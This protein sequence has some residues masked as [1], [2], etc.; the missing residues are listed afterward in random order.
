LRR[1]SVLKNDY[2]Q[3]INAA[4]DHILNNLD[5]PLPLDTVADAAGL[6][7]FHFHRVFK[8]IQGETLLE[9]T[10]RIRLERAISKMT[11]APTRPL[12][13]VATECGFGSQS[14]FSRCFKKRFGVA[15]SAFDVDSF[16]DQRRQEWKSTVADEKHI[17]QLKG[18]PPGVNPDGFT[19]RIRELPARR[20]AYIRVLDPYRPDVVA[21]AAQR[22]VVWAEQH[23]L[24]G[25]QW[26]GYMWEDPEVT[27]TK[28]CRYDAAVEA[29]RFT[30]EGEVCSHT[31][32][33]MLVAQVDIRGPIDVEVRALDW[34]FKTWLPK[35]GY[36]PA[37]QPAFEAWH[38]LPFAHGIEHF[39]L[40]I[41]LP[42]E[43]ARRWRC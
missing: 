18:L 36:V 41:Q 40:S 25:G 4:I 39:E 10:Q 35:S 9:F 26:L 3:R 8:A 17:H 33:P 29:E 2:V 6:S 11:H 42:I 19:A 20:V 1:A 15:P 27:D 24:A 38:G 12:A 5:Q 21:N 32:P 7:P 28:R 43:S 37:A 31:F 22:L 13:D 34:L 30:P 16:R 14:D 23:D